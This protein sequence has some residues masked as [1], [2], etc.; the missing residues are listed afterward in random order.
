MLGA[1]VEFADGEGLVFTGRLSLA[2]HPWLADHAVMGVVLLPGT[3]FVELAAHAGA[4]V[5][6]ERV[7]ELTLQAPLVLAGDAAVVV[8]VRVEAPD[9]RGARGLAVYSRGQDDGASW[10][11][12][13]CGCVTPRRC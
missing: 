2:T 9:E 4:V 10:V 3:A 5:G 6:C 1:A 7:E 13:G 11:R 8:Q 12:R